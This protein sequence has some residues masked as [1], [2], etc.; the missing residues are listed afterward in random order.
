MLRICGLGLACCY[1]NGKNVCDEV[2]TTPISKYDSR[3]YYNTYDVTNLLTDGTN[4]I[5]CI[6]GNG[7]YFVTYFRWDYYKPHGCIIRSCCWN[8]KLP[9]RMERRK[10]H[11]DT[12]WKTADSA[13][14]YNETRRGE[15]FDARRYE[16][17]WNLPQYDDSKWIMLLF[18]AVRA[19]YCRRGIFL[20]FG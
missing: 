14:L 18:A 12:S 15:I 9:M 10:N 1:I 17:E 8:W 5:G 16:Q 6:L 11:S 13:V 20:P 2:L 19:E 3:L 4:T 7:W